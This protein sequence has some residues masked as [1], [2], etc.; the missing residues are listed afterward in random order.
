LWQGTTR[1][2]TPPERLTPSQWA[3]RYRVLSRRQ[4]SRPGRWDNRVQP[5]LV[6]IMDLAW[7][8]RGVRKI[9]IRKAAQVGVSEALRNII[10]CLA[11]LEPDPVLL[12][13]P[14]EK[15]GKRVMTKR[16]L[17][18]F[19]DTPCLKALATNVG[20]D[21]Q[22]TSVL[23]ANGFNLQLGWTG[24]AATLA[25][26]PARVAAIDETDKSAAWRG[27]ESGPV[28]LVDV[29]TTTYENSLVLTMS[30]PTTADGPITLL[31]ENAQIKLWYFVPCPHCGFCQRLTFERIRYPKKVDGKV[32]PKPQCLS[33]IADSDWQ[34]MAEEPSKVRRAALVEQHRAAWYECEK[35]QGAILDHQKQRMLIAGYWGTDDGGYKLFFD[36]HEEGQFPTGSEV[37]MH[38]PAEYSLAAKHK[39]YRMVAE[40]FLCEG[41]PQR[42]QG[43]YNSWRG[44]PFKLQIKATPPG[45]IRDKANGAPPPL[46]VPGWARLLVATADLQGNDPSTG[47]FYYVVRAWSYEYRSQLIDYGIVSTFEELK[48]K[49]IDRLL[50]WEGGS[51]VSPKMLLID[52]G[53]RANEVYQFALSDPS[54]IKPTKGASERLSWPVHKSLQRQSGVVLW[55]IDTEQT[56]DLLNRLI[57]S[58]DPM[59]WRVHSQINDDYCQQLSAETKVIDPRTKRETWQKKSGSTPNHL[60]DCESMQ[61]A[62]AWDEGCGHPDPQ[63]NPNGVSTIQSQAEQHN[64][65]VSAHDAIFG[66]RQRH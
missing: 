53:N 42:T 39:F 66:Y 2:L 41:D 23:L 50:P 30:T 9:H 44:E 1:A 48:A 19:E 11:H 31:T 28:E 12:V 36:G 43:F 32:T 16:I 58:P 55:N 54:R 47:Y 24:S 62:A 6:G 20:H 7:K 17:P 22:Q 40:W 15:T 5:C 13:L 4:S 8:Q 65:T 37:A 18:L 34:A 26:D 56:K 35:C 57:H 45:A 49:T 27:K 59:Q 29:R 64:Q 21:Q 38:L 51:P 3:S 60:L 10:G 52:S 63:T 25:A 46:I 61:C 33:R 14:D